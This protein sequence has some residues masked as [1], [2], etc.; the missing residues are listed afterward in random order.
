MRR[1]LALLAL[2]LATACTDPTVEV[3]LVFPGDGPGSL[4]EA[5]T[6]YDL[7]VVVANADC[8]AARYLELSAA[9]LRLGTREFIHDQPAGVPATLTNVPRVDPKLFVVTGYDLAGAV[10]AGG[11][12]EVRDA[13]EADRPVPISME[14][15]LITRVIDSEAVTPSLT[16]ADTDAFELLARERRRDGAP[17]SQAALRF[18]LRTGVGDLP[19]TTSGDA[20]MVTV[21]KVDATDS[22]FTVSGLTQLP[23]DQL[24]GDD[25][26]AGAAQLV[27]RG[28]WSD[29][30]NRIPVS[31]QV[32]PARAWLAADQAPNQIAPSW[33]TFD[34]AEPVGC[35]NV[36]AL[37]QR[38]A[39]PP[40]LVSF[41]VTTTGAME[42][43]R[44]PDLPGA[45]ALVAFQPTV[46][47][48]VTLAT[49]TATGW[50]TLEFVD[51]AWQAS[52]SDE[53]TVAAD[54]LLAF[55]PC[56]S[57]GSVGVLAVT[58]TTAR[59][60][61]SLERTPAADGVDSGQ[62]AAALQAWLD[63][64]EA[65]EL[66]GA[67]CVRGTTSDGE[68]TT[69]PAL[70]VRRT[71][72][73]QA[74]TTLLTTGPSQ[75]TIIDTN[76][77][78][79]VTAA[80][81]GTNPSVIATAVVDNGLR[82]QSYRLTRDA[83]LVPDGIISHPV[84]A[85]P[86]ALASLDANGD[87]IDDTVALVPVGADLGVAMTLGGASPE[88]AIGA[89]L[90][91]PTTDRGQRVVALGQRGATGHQRLLVLGPDGLGRFDFAP[92][93]RR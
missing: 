69:Q 83:R 90:R 33:V 72:A 19:L 47:G 1:H 31:I 60:Y 87:D 46:Q 52:P 27:I 3:Q 45:R 93:R 76:L 73:T 15:A 91:L 26:P 9:D 6:S 68:L 50:T 10:I 49:R 38:A 63:D 66:L 84:P 36:A 67:A 86:T 65:V 61:L 42:P 18:V 28:A 30:V 85:T 59:G 11:C 89:T 55:P 12:A 16:L 57:A 54:Q 43:T 14:P 39:G 51:D 8:D 80:A 81:L 32:D 37:H 13:I 21:T 75:A 29:E 88:D 48:P 74:T 71:S 41:H 64:G 23:L 20:P 24:P 34:C 92:P 4:A 53:V 79:A 77:L 78:G 2:G 7:A 22:V 25:A 70:A 62:F 40:R 17:V 56:G 58:G 82:V 5:V 35:L 44:G